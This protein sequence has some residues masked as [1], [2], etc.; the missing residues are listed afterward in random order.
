MDRL[1]RSLPPGLGSTGRHAAGF[2]YKVSAGAGEREAF[3]RPSA[4]P[5]GASGKSVQ[6]GVE[7]VGA[8][9]RADGGFGHGQEAGVRLF[10]GFGLR[11]WP[12]FKGAPPEAASA[13]EPP[14]GSGR[15]LLTV[16]WSCSLAGHHTSHMYYQQASKGVAIGLFP[17][18]RALYAIRIVALVW[19]GGGWTGTAGGEKECG[20]SARCG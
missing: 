18:T 11:V 17:L 3:R 16:G 20:A 2:I 15:W 8:R 12:A 14:A 9:S 19:C 6:A 5:A 13:P 1:P 4:K 7:T 10:G